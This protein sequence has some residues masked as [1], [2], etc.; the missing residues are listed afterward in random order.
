MIDA[1]LNLIMITLKSTG[2][3]IAFIA[4]I[5]LCGFAI[6][7]AFYLLAA[8]IATIYNKSVKLYY[9]IRNYYRRDKQ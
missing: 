8:S 6:F 1:L 4:I 9:D 5:C 7:F 2:L 3:L